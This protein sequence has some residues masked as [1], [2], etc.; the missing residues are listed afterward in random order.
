[1]PELK[2]VFILGAGFSK[3]ANMPLADELLE[4]LI[5]KVKDDEIS[6]W[7]DRLR[8]RLAWLAGEDGAANPFRLNIEQVFHHAQTDSEFHRL[9]QHLVPVGRHDGPSTPWNQAEAVDHWLSYLEHALRDAILKCDIESNLQPISRWA[10][11][12]A[13]TDTV[14]TFNYDRL[15]ERALAGAGL[16]WN[17][18][19]DRDANGGIP[20]LK[21]HG[22]IDWIVAHR[23]DAVSEEKTDLI[24]DKENSNRSDGK[25]G[26]VEDDCRLWRCRTDHQLSFWMK[27]RD[28]QS[29]PEGAQPRS[30][31]IAGLGA[32]KELH[33]IPGLG[34]IWGRGMRAL[35]QADLAIIV[36]FSMSD[37]DTMAQMQ[38]A[39]VARARAKD[40]KPL[41][42][43]VVDPFANELTK[44][45]F[46]RVF[47][48]V[49][50][51]L[52]RHEECDWTTLG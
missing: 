41:R 39:E 30:V 22:S 12:L 31:G 20:I 43:L 3:P 28:L 42:V 8:E 51:K 37:F 27:G 11:H 14:M 19:F 48:T 5:Q 50:F 24:F 29:P 13:S 44:E 35:Y 40:G 1:M 26:H 2:R 38:F 4:I 25:T 9:C 52:K 21:L 36:G 23:H 32:Y 47:R 15:P 46:K 17:H 6:G 7:L 45:R 34:H 18:G 10:Q 16:A 49:D 33:Q